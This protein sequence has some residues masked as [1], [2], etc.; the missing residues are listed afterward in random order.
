MAVPVCAAASV[1]SDPVDV[2]SNSVATS[3]SSL[4]VSSRGI[5]RKGGTLPTGICLSKAAIGAGALSIAAHS[6][7]VG[8]AYQFVCLLVGAL[9]TV[10]S[11]QMIADASVCTGGWSYE[12]ICEELFHPA[13]SLFTGFINVCNCLGSGAG[14]LI[15]CG[16]VFQVLFGASAAARNAFVVVVGVLVC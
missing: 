9:L 11:V 6:A 15:V 1:P 3:D 12:D 2:E 5:F 7:E 13:M 10:I 8:F 4:K 16:Q 14:Y